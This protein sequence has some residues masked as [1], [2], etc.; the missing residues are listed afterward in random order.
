[1]FDSR[2]HESVGPAWG[3]ARQ[4]GGGPRTHI[5]RR[6]LHPAATVIGLLFAGL[7]GGVVLVE[8]VFAWPGIGYWATQAVLGFDAGGIMGTTLIFALFLVLINL[9][10]DVMYAYLDPRISL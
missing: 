2:H 7:L 10:A 3:K 9:A 6:A 5:W 8:D 4:Q 1:M